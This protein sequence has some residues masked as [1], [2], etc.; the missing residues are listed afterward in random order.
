[1][2]WVEDAISS[3]EEHIKRSKSCLGQ[4]G[5]AHRFVEHVSWSECE[6]CGVTESKTDYDRKLECHA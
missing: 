4:L 1:M 6:R 2:S 3:Q 5:L